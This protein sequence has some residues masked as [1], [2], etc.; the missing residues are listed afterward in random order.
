M[1]VVSHSINQY[2][3]CISGP[4]Y[5]SRHSHPSSPL[6][7]H[8]HLAALLSTQLHPTPTPKTMLPLKPPF[9]TLSLFLSPLFQPLTG[10][11]SLI[12]T[13]QTLLLNDIPYYVPA[14]P[15]A[16]LPLPSPLQSAAFA[17]GL[18]PVTVVGLSAGNAGLSGLEQAISGFGGDDVWNWG[19]GQGRWGV[20]FLS[21]VLVRGSVSLDLSS[22]LGY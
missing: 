17:G 4:P 14:T 6:S 22:L 10:A 21:M 20:V 8:P 18:A 12:S 1:H 2:R 19:F 11:A 3:T 7:Q 5:L 15:F 9:I 16:T 13:G